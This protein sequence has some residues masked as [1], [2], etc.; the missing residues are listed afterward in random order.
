M[1]RWNTKN[2]TYIE[3]NSI[4][5]FLNEIEKIC[6]K[7][8]FSLSHEDNHGAFLIEK[9]E[10]KNVKWLKSAIDNTNQS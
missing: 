2:K 5:N 9:F 8:N 7:Y 1:K 3:N 4:D 10:E 6:Q